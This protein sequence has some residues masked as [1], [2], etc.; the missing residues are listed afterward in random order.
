MNDR[1]KEVVRWIALYIL[2]HEEDVRR[3]LLR[4]VPEPA[5]VNDIIQQAYCRLSELDYT[6]HIRNARAYFFSTARS[7]LLERL[8]RERIV[9]IQA[10]A[11]FEVLQMV[12]ERPS[13]EA[14]AGAKIELRAV[15]A[16]LD[17]LPPAYRDALKLRRIEGLS[18]REAAQRLGVSEKIVEN[19]TARGLKMLLS[20]LQEARAKAELRISHENGGSRAYAR[21]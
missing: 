9:Q 6:A 16:A 4:S 19:N 15:M 10:V 5:D 14:A 2:P 3:V 1:R 11:D 7:I 20:T 17:R 21:H 18:L 12:D 8:R 13:P